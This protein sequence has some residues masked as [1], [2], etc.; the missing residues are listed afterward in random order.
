M[1]KRRRGKLVAKEGLHN[2]KEDSSKV[3][4]QLERSQLM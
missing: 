4:T 2:A 3:E 1:K